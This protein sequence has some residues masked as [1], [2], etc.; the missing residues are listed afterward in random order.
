MKSKF[1]YLL[2]LCIIGNYIS[3]QNDKKVT[4]IVRSAK[5]K[6][7][8]AFASVGITGTGIGTVTNESGMFTLNIP[9]ENIK[10]SI[11]ISYIGFKSWAGKI[12][13]QGDTLFFDLEPE[14]YLLSSVI[15]LPPGIT[16][17][18]I[19]K[20]AIKRISKNYARKPF[21]QLAF[22]R[23][24][25]TLDNT[26][27]RLIEAA[28]EVQDF[29]YDA[30]AERRRIK[31]VEFR[32]SDDFIET[33]WKDFLVKT[34]YGSSNDLIHTFDNCDRAR[35]LFSNK[36]EIPKGLKIVLNGITTFD[37]VEVFEIE[38]Q[39]TQYY[40]LNKTTYFINKSDYAI[41]QISAEAH[42]GV[43]P[44]KKDAKVRAMMDAS[45]WVMLVKYKK[46]GDKY[47]MY[48]GKY[49]QP[50]SL[51]AIDL[52]KT[53]KGQQF[54][55]QEILINNTITSRSDWDRVKRKERQVMDKDL[56][57][58]DFVYHPSFWS[59]YIILLRNPLL[60]QVITDL[61]RGKTLE[62]QFYDNGN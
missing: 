60:K 14:T 40:L 22:Y 21:Y 42:F 17:E 5:D 37:G 10:D 12:K 23:E 33:N 31:V 41:L 57:K 38:V 1:A 54:K 56:Y 19:Y 51:A 62:E 9:S 13:I 44:E 26:F 35:T 46:I 7:R 4:G 20:E 11:K 15:I 47:Y 25:A 59:N 18:S 3:A 49:I 61:N 6:D 36:G 28:V 52:K 53:G 32:K 34:I 45:R 39:D 16:A 50:E 30:A 58:Q 24:M 29:G 27:T 8:L 43:S 2:L 55:S 48:Y